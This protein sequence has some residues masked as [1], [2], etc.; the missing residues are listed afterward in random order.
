M[1]NIWIAGHNHML[2]LAYGCELILCSVSPF[3]EQ[4]YQYLTA[5]HSLW[6]IIFVFPYMPGMFPLQDLSNNGLEVPPCT[7]IVLYC[8]VLYCIV[9]YCIALHCAAVLHCIVLYCI[10]LYCIY[11]FSSNDDLYR[12]SGFCNCFICRLWC[13][14]LIA[15]LNFCGIFSHIKFWKNC[16]WA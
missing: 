10:V 3:T 9:L 14:G 5:M 12:L 1:F 11:I 7:S 16:W 2:G 6:V 8:I 15:C 4:Y 13:H